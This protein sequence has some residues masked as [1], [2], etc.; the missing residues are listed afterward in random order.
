MPRKTNDS[1]SAEGAGLLASDI[2]EYWRNRGHR[3]KVWLDE[4]VLDPSS[5]EKTGLF[6][7]R[8]NLLNGKPR[9]AE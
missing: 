8:S 4:L 6:V 2:R 9:P 7:I 1:F 3:V 5:K